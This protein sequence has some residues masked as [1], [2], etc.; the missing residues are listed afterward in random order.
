MFRFGDSDYKASNKVLK[1]HEEE[2]YKALRHAVPGL[3]TDASA[4][5][6]AL[7]VN[8]SGRSGA[9]GAGSGIGASH[10]PLV[11]A[12]AFNVS[13]L[14]GPTLAFLDRVKEVMPAGLLGDED[15]AS[16]GFSGFLDEFVLK[17]FLP[18]LEDKVSTVF[19]QAAGGELRS[20]L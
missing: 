12:D 7:S 20:E 6:S 11:R 17:T 15:S 8:S 18:Q 14:F 19:H 13:I 4:T 5:L 2:L 10:K 16:T 9:G 3:L 1:A